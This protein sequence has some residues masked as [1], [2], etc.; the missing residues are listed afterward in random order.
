M[1]LYG[2]RHKPTGNYMPAKMFRTSGAG[3]SYWEPT[4]VDGFGGHDQGPRLFQTEH[5]A[6][7]ALGQWLAGRWGPSHT[8]GAYFDPPEYE[9]L[10]ARKPIAPRV[11]ED[12][13]I[14][15]FSLVPL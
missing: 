8:Q 10:V 11:R 6:K 3:Y 7:V 15:A 9:G 14:V 13:E 4:G 5:A 1:K 2:I 12:M